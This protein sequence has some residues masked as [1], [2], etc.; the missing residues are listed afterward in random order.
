MEHLPETF[1]TAS[2]SYNSYLIHLVHINYIHLKRTIPWFL[3][4]S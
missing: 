1:L 2:L 4:Y 3:V